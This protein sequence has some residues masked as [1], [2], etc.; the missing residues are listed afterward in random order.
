VS[1]HTY[2]SEWD[3]RKGEPEDK[4][5]VF[6]MYLKM[7]DRSLIGLS[8]AAKVHTRTLTDWSKKW[9]WADR[10][11]AW[12]AEQNRVF[13]QETR[14]ALRDAIGANAKKKVQDIMG[15]HTLADMI[16][17]KLAMVAGWPLERMVTDE[18]T[19]DG[20]Y[21]IRNPQRWSLRDAEPLGNIYMKLRQYAYS[22]GGMVDEDRGAEFRRDQD[23]VDAAIEAISEVRQRKELTRE[24]PDDGG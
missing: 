1:S 5:N 2:F 6:K 16:G 17:N 21:V 23:E 13:E 22:L 10:A 11:R 19:P 18:Q 12:D 8:A 15:A 4:Y 24:G 20:R 3:R 9:E 7:K 14:R